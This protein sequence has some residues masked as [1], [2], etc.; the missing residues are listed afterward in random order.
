MSGSGN[1]SRSKLFVAQFAQEK[2]SAAPQS[3]PA[4]P[5]ATAAYTQKLDGVLFGFAYWAPHGD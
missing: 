2:E 1:R 5:E 3:F 4:P